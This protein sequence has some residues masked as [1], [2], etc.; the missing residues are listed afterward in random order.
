MYK[1]V[2]VTYANGKIDWGKAKSQI[3]FAIIRCGLE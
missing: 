1:G 3:D 2:D